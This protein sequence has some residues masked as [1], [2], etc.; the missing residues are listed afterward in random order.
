MSMDDT[1]STSSQATLTAR[2]DQEFPIVGIGASAG[3]LDAIER[4]FDH[5][6]INTGMAFVIVQ[7][8]SPDFKSL[9]NEL[10]A[11]H[12]EMPI[13]RVESGM[14]VQPNHIYLIPPKKNMKLANGR[15]MLIEQ[16][17]K[18]TVNLPIDIFLTSLAESAGDRAVA[19]IL[20]GTGSDGTRGVTEVHK[21]GGLVLAQDSESA[22]FDIMPRSAVETEVVDIV[23]PPERM[24]EKLMEYNSGSGFHPD[25]EPDDEFGALVAID[26]VEGARSEIFRMFRHQF[27]IDF[28]LYKEATMNRRIERR[29]QLTNTDGI[30]E[31][32][33]KLETD[34]DELETL[35]RDL[36]VEVTQFFR[37]PEAF[38]VLRKKV[39]PLL[40][41]D[42]PEGGEIRVWAPGCATGEEA[43]SLAM[44]FHSEIEDSGKDA[45]VKVFATDVHSKS[46]EYGSAG[47]YTQSAMASLPEEF[48]NRYFTSN[49]DLYHVTRELR[50]VV[51]FAPNDLTRDPPFTKMDLISCRNVLIYLEPKVQKRILSLFHFGLR[52]RG[53]LLLG[54]SESLGDLDIEFDTI[55]RNWR[56][57]RKERD[58]RLPLA[59]RLPMTS[60]IS[61][62]LPGV[63]P[64]VAK[65]PQRDGRDALVGAYEQLL[66]KYVPPSLLVNENHELLHSF[67]SARELLIQP[68]GRPTL[69]VLKLV[70]GDLRMAISAALHKANQSR[71]SVTFRSVR[72]RSGECDRLFEVVVDPYIRANERLYLIS[73]E[74]VELP[75]V[76]V[77]E[78]D[79]FD[80][81]EQSNKRISIL[82]QELAYT[83][84][85]LQSTVEELETS[86]EELQ[87]TNEELLTSNEELQSTNEELH[88]VNEELY[89]VNAEHKQKIEELTELTTDMDNL[90]KSTEI[91]TLFLDSERCIRMFTPSIASAFNV[92]EQDIG[93]PIDHIAYK[94]KYPDLLDDI[95]AVLAGGDSM[96]H[97]VE[98]ED[99][100]TFLQRIRPYHT[101][102]GEIGGIT[103]TFTDISALKEVEQ[104]RQRNAELK[105]SNR[106]LQDFAYAVSHDLNTPLRHISD[107]CRDLSEP[108]NVNLSEQQQKEF[109]QIVAASSDLTRMIQGLLTYSRV[110]TRGKELVPVDA[111][112]VVSV[113]IEELQLELTESET[114]ITIADLPTVRVDEDQLKQVF[115][116]LVDNALKYRA[117]RPLEISINCSSNNG[118]W[119]FEVVDNGIGIEQRHLERVF[120][121]FQRLGFQPE[122][123]GD[124]LGLAL[125]KRIIERH[126]G[127]IGVKS[128][129]GEG[130]TFYFTL[131]M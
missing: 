41:R 118:Y 58:V 96:E 129:A 49:G 101:S 76:P 68:E 93:R 20:S 4:L 44:L 87:S 15:L 12:T 63:T 5:M 69:D 114:S 123:A 131:P 82:E 14:T 18:G 27:G 35:Y 105:R 65:S 11:R 62:A 77:T 29:I 95:S 32:L 16:E 38:D 73:L 43:Y 17:K 75:V 40:V 30:E 25:P 90:L 104:T 126:G 22:G 70:K 57:F 26:A 48:Q 91:G 24:P 64:F 9:M 53:V 19:V 51:I 67:G 80:V 23:C 39:V 120:V 113:A 92:L 111:N 8:L 54:P 106:D 66:S 50:Q 117:D 79:Q 125:C 60:P 34:N 127:K 94:L 83:G 59:S 107:S 74:E 36:L 45:T 99:H 6:P 112:T 37:D 28:T 7:H 84:E 124:G 47:V 116:Q 88:S 46:L 110:S 10:L 72:V 89:T 56:V 3:G 103:M 81:Q 85:S 71:A 97:E 61:K 102:R 55:D 52:T 21:H 33:R 128:E 115:V 122:V 121:V 1:S 119:R 13:F 98:S 86:N 78:G 31:Y 109:K 100:R 130:S 108:I 2:L 42:A